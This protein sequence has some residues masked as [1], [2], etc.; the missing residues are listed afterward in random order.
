MRCRVLVKLRN[1]ALTQHTQ[2]SQ[3]FKDSKRLGSIY[4]FTVAPLLQFILGDTS[5]CQ[6]LCL[7]HFWY[8]VLS[9]LSMWLWNTAWSGSQLL[10]TTDEK[11]FVLRV[12]PPQEHVEEQTCQLAITPAVA[13]CLQEGREKKAEWRFLFPED[14]VLCT[15]HTLLKLLLT[16]VHLES[17]RM[18][19]W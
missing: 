4:H 5:S 1:S 15:R 6:R 9:W 7:L 17:S 8:S 19:C 18:C 14:I 12:L 13:S 2:C 16:E 11:P 10:V 3:Q